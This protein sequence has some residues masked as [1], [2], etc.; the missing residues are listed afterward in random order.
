MSSILINCESEHFAVRIPKRYQI[1]LGSTSS[2]YSSQ[3]NYIESDKNNTK[4]INLSSSDSNKHLNSSQCPCELE[5]S[6]ELF[7]LLEND[8]E[9]TGNRDDFHSRVFGQ[10]EKVRWVRCTKPGPD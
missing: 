4:D 10:F 7:H 2:F 1:S 3:D 6:L 9:N 5:G 8:K